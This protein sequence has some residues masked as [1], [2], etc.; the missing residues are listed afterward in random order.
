MQEKILIINKEKDI[1]SFLESTLKEK[2]YIVYTVEDG[3]IGVEKVFTEK[4]DLILLDAMISKELD[5]E[6]CKILR[7]DLSTSSIPVIMII[8]KDRSFDKLPELEIGPDDFIYK[9]FDLDEV[10]DEL[11]GKIEFQLNRIKKGES[12]EI[13]KVP[14]GIKSLDSVLSGGLPKGS[15]IL[16]IGPFGS[17]KSTLARRFI[18]EG[19]K[20]KERCLLVLIDED[21]KIIRRDIDLRIRGRLESLEDDGFFRIVDAYSWSIGMGSSQEKFTVSGIIDMSELS[22]LISDAGTQLGQTSKDKKGGRRII[23]SISSLLV[24]FELPSVQRFIS[25]IAR[26]ANPF[27]GI[28]TLFIMEEGGVSDIVLNN[29]KYLMD[30]VIELKEESWKRFLRVTSMKWTSHIKEWVEIK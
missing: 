6:I 9:Q 21:P 1:N 28:N 23:D 8:P 25:H 11:I 22:G 30:G 7:E 4:P 17:G 14:T 15:N 27:G 12:I 20:R 10:L 24:N 29:I 13:E 16:V 5:Y 18:L 19:L 26:S 3:R 2:N